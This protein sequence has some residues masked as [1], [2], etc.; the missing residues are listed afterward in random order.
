MFTDTES[1]QWGDEWRR[2]IDAAIAAVRNFLGEVSAEIATRPEVETLL[3]SLDE[4]TAAGTETTSTMR[5]MVSQLDETAK[6]S[7][8]LRPQLRT[9]KAAVRSV[10]DVQPLLDEWRLRVEEIRGERA[11]T[12][13]VNTTPS[14]S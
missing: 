11:S 10:V 8:A 14:G 12:S 6:I 5:Q 9:I 1:L 3:N 13:E 2:E 4:M 7:R